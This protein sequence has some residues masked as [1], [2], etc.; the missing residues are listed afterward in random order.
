MNLTI[1]IMAGQTASIHICDGKTKEDFH[2]IADH[3]RVRCLRTKDKNTVMCFT[4]DAIDEIENL[5]IK[6]IGRN[7][8]RCSKSLKL[9][10]N[11]TKGEA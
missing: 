9:D 11:L 3:N 2:W 5:S 4:Y 8:R 10:T 1:P 7:K 6:G